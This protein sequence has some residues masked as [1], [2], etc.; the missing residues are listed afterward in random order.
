VLGPCV[1]RLLDAVDLVARV[2][3]LGLGDE[4]DGLDELPLTPSLVGLLRESGI[5][6]IE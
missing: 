3:L 2:V 4:V 1:E 6:C 5:E